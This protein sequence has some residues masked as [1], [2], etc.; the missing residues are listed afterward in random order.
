MPARSADCASARSRHPN[1]RSI[2]GAID[3]LTKS[4]HDLAVVLPQL[5]WSTINQIELEKRIIISNLR[6]QL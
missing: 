2:L 5:A 1:F 4:E 6:I 3:F